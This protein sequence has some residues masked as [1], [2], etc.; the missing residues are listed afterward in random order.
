MKPP[1]QGNR[2][3]LRRRFG[4]AYLCIRDNKPPRRV[5]QCYQR[6]AEQHFNDRHIALLILVDLSKR[7][8]AIYPVAIVC[9]DSEAGVVLVEGGKVHGRAGAHGESYPG[10]VELWADLRGSLRAAGTGN[11]DFDSE[12]ECSW[13]VE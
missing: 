13:T 7:L 6:G 11:G 1:Q 2:L 12:V 10:G 3:E 5:N 4:H 8:A 9:T